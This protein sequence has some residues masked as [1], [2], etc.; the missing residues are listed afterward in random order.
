MLKKARSFRDLT[1]W[2]KAH[3]F[4]PAIYQI[5]KVFPADERFGL[6]SQIRR[7]S[8]SVAANIAEGFSKRSK[9]DKVRFFNIAQGSLEEFHYYLILGHDLGYAN[10]TQLADLYREVAR[11]LN[12]YSRAILNSSS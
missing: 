8:V 1:V 2:Q 4:V 10:C 11:L 12:G 7:A 6:T 3:Q 9:L 5:T